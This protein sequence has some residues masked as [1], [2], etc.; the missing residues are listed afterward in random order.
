M[1]LE[2]MTILPTVSLPCYIQSINDVL[3]LSCKELKGPRLEG[4][5]IEWPKCDA[6]PKVAFSKLRS[7][8]KV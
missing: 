8:S 5:I 2:V 3:Q 6:S 7:G 1:G 4:P